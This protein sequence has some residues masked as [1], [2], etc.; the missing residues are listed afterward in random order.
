M[1]SFRGFKNLEAKR[2]YH[3]GNVLVVSLRA[4]MIKADATAEE[5]EKVARFYGRLLRG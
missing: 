3:P 2:R 1:V 5:L 4:N